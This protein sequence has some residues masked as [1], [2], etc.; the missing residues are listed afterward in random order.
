[1]NWFVIIAIFLIL[2]FFG[3]DI[4]KLLC[5]VA[6]TLIVYC[7]LHAWIYGPYVINNL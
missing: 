1:M 6:G 5:V 3:W 4:L 2:L 7:L